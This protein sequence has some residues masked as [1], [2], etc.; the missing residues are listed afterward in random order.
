M[1]TAKRAEVLLDP[2]AYDRLEER[3]AREGISLSELIGRAVEQTFPAPPKTARS[4]VQRIAAL[5]LPLA[6]WEALEQ[7]ILDAR[8]GDLR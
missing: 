2:D 8:A 7:E 6:D 5:N 1:A 3:A 4:A